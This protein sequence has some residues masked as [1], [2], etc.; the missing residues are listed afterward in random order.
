MPDDLSVLRQWVTESFS[1]I[2]NHGYGLQDF[3]EKPDVLTDL[4]EMLILNSV[5]DKNT[6]C[7]HYLWNSDIE[8]L[9]DGGT[10]LLSELLCHEGQGGLYQT[11]VQLGYLESM[12]AYDNGSLETVLWDFVIEF[13]LTDKGMDSWQHVL[14]IFSAFLTFAQKDVIDLPLFGEVAQMTQTSFNYYKVAEQQDNVVNIASKMT[15]LAK[16]PERMKNLLKVAYEETIVEKVNIEEIQQL[17]E[18]LAP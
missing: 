15:L 9:L 16:K 5:K 8:A 2:T 3:R 7:L 6:L 10:H 4:N 14:S 13:T 18:K 12:T 1:T 17:L 11:L